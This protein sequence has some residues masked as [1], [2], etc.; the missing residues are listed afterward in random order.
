M[1]SKKI[2]PEEAAATAYDVSIK[3]LDVSSRVYQ[4][5]MGAMD[6]LAEKTD[7]P[8]GRFSG[9]SYNVNSY[10][11]MIE[12]VKGVETKIVASIMQHP[13]KSFKEKVRDVAQHVSDKFTHESTVA[14]GFFFGKSAVVSPIAIGVGLAVAAVSPAS[15]AVAGYCA[16]KGIKMAATYFLSTHHGH[17]VECQIAEKIKQGCRFLRGMHRANSGAD[18][19]YGQAAELAQDLQEI[20]EHRAHAAHGHNHK[21]DHSHHHAHRHHHHHVKHTLKEDLK[22]VQKALG[23]A[24]TKPKTLARDVA[25]FDFKQEM[26]KLNDVLGRSK[27]LDVQTQ[28]PDVTIGVKSEFVVPEKASPVIA[29]ASKPSVKNQ[30][31]KL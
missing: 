14:A 24:F 13:E 20:A 10:K 26:Q 19:E 25:A 21:D 12:C 5:V 27:V 11:A 18:P 4:K 31:M 30:G 3:S 2:T 6:Y 22:A 23:S 7:N 15:A 1:N 28:K 8:L 9:M 17:H 16:Y 29:A